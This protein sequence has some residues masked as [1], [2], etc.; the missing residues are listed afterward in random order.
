MGCPY[1]CVFCDQKSITNAHSFSA[2]S[3]KNDIETVL[4]TITGGNTEIAYF[5]GSFTGIDRKLMISLLDLAQSY[6]DAEKV[7]GI[8]FSTRPDYINTDIINILSDY[9]ISEVELGVQSANDNVLSISKRG[10]TLKDTL[11]AFDLLNNAGINFGGQMMLGL[12]GST[13]KTEIETAELISQSGAV[14]SRIYPCLV[15]KNTELYS[16]FLGGSYCPLTTDD[17]VQRGAKVLKVFVE[18]RINVLRI[19]LQDNE[20]LHSEDTFAAGPNEPCLGEMIKSAYYLNL[21]KEQLP[22]VINRDCIE[23][24]CAKGETSAVSG[25]KKYNKLYLMKNAGTKYIKIL[26][27]SDIKSYNIIIK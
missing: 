14:S 4:S 8:R 16:M 13:L 3:V 27:N 23:I 9:S 18:N 10:H 6:V 19:G 20:N 1:K 24:Y 11:K 15:F 2:E 25:Y 26:E 5:G 21:I 7:T 12:P 17:A 22:K